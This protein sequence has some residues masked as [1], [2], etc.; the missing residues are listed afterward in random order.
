LVMKFT[1]VA[2]VPVCAVLTAVHWVS[3]RN[4]RGFWKWLPLVVAGA[5]AVVLAV[6]A[7]QWRPAPALSVAQAGRIGVPAWFRVLR[8]VLIPPDFFKGLALQGAHASLGHA[9][10]LCGQWGQTG[11]WYYFPVA[12]ALKLPVPLV[13]LTSAGAALWLARLRSFSFD[14]AVPWLAA[15]VYFGL[16]MLGTINIGIRYLLPMMPLLAVGTASQI[17]A[18]KPKQ[19]IMAWA[20]V[21]WLALVT[22]RAHPFYL[23]Y[24]NE[25]AGGSTKGYTKLVDSNLDWGQDVKRLKRFLEAQNIQHVSLSYF[26]PPRAIEY[27]GIGANR[28]SA[29]EAR[30]LRAG[31]LVVSATTLMRPEWAW[32]R[33]NQTPQARVGYT[34]F[35]YQMSGSTPR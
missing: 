9:A 7:P 18:L 19:R 22:L 24:F 28:V 20:C 11:W 16:A 21:A 34:L 8:P 1:A 17:A 10:F 29:E 26:G 31:A 3:R 23:E 14:R 25:L 12:L 2:L 35:V 33:E 6:Y 5:A 30:A 27:Y 13:V 32:L 15:A 4:S